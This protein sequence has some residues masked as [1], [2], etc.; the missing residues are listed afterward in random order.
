MATLKLFQGILGPTRPTY[1]KTSMA[2]FKGTQDALDPRSPT[3][4]L[5]DKYLL[6]QG[7]LWG[8]WGERG[9]REIERGRE[10][11]RERERRERGGMWVDQGGGG[12][13]V[14]MV[15]LQNKLIF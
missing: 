10:R 8:H 11:E 1:K 13:V 9:G 5:K 7:V 12:L 6:I 15:F 3:P 2:T 4:P 14:L